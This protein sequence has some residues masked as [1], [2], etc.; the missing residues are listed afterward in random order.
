[1]V[2]YSSTGRARFPPQQAKNARCPRPL[3]LN[4]NRVKCSKCYCEA[5]N[6]SSTL[7]YV[8]T[9]HSRG[10]AQ[11][12]DGVSRAHAA[13]MG[14]K[15]QQHAIKSEWTPRHCASIESRVEGV[16]P[17]RM[18]RRVAKLDDSVQRGCAV[19]GGDDEREQRRRLCVTQLGMRLK[20]DFLHFSETTAHTF[21][22]LS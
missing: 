16:F 19:V 21:D 9:S 5:L 2:C 3:I 22:T 11:S 10:S 6:R 12:L 7:S 20:N 17:Q 15:Q 8:A 13:R 1:M 14:G 18:V 4:R